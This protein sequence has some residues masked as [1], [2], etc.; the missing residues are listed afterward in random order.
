ML[1][2]FSRT[3][4]AWGLL[5]IGA[6]L[7]L[8]IALFFQYV[9]GLY[10]CVMCVYQRAALAGVILAA[11]PGW[12]APRNG[13]VTGLALAG[14]LAAS[15]KGFW[16]AN[17]HVGYQLNPSP[18]NQCSSFADFPQWLALDRWWPALFHPSGDCS[19]TSWSWL[20]WSMPQW[21]M[22]I[23]AVLAGLA[24]FFIIVRI[25]GVRRKA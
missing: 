5:T 9:Q 19:D 10:P 3:R 24:A 18:F 13:L 12:L 15:V 2:D 22:G 4:L 7:L 6:T 25:S 23:F 8:A 20:G 1:Y 16:L 17:E 11:L 14:W 21:L